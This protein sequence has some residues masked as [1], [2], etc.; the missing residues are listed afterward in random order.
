MRMVAGRVSGTPIV[1]SQGASPMAIP[2]TSQYD[3]Y[4]R[5]AEDIALMRDLGVN[6]YRFSVSWPRIM[7]A[8]RGPQTQRDSRFYDRLIDGLIAAGIEPWLC[9]YHW[10]LPQALGERGGWTSRVLCPMVRRLRHAD[11]PP[12]W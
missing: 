2:A 3:H 9:L 12:L 1:G 10:D 5:Y 11:W 4:H 7:P 6:A 8:G